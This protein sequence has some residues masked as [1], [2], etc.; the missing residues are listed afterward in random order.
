[1][2]RQSST[3]VPYEA[4]MRPDNQVIMTSGRAGVVVPLGYIPIL[5]GESLSGR[6]GVDI[7]LAEMPKPAHWQQRH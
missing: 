7:K 2:T 3:P 4:S 6:I 1:M 5:P